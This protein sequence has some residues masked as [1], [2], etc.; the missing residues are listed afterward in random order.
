MLLVIASGMNL[1][2]PNT[3]H[4]AEV[5][6]RVEQRVEQIESNR[7]TNEDGA[8]MGAKVD[9]NSAAILASTE[10]LATL[11][12]MQAETNRRL[13]VIEEALRIREMK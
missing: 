8:I 3:V 2:L 6:K 5:E 7:F 11:L 13:E 10:T 9:A 1:F 12:T 4:E